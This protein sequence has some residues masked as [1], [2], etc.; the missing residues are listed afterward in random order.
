MTKVRRWAIF[1]S[2]VGNAGSAKT[3][4]LCGYR[5]EQT[6][7]SLASLLA[8]QLGWFALADQ[9]FIETRFSLRLPP[10]S[11]LVL[12]DFGLIPLHQE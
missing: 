11:L 2:M 6:G 1:D 10:V 9:L 8:E 4:W 12:D 7:Q 5:P 3:V